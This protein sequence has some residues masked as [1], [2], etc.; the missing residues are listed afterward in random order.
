MRP[1]NSSAQARPSSA[2]AWY[3]GGAGS[4]DFLELVQSVLGGG[5]LESQFGEGE[6]AFGLL[7]QVRLPSGGEVIERGAELFGQMP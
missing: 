5:V 3:A 4:R 2:R 1:S 7:P 6:P